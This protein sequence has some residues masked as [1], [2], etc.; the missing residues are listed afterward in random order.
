MKSWKRL[1]EYEK[2][3]IKDNYLKQ[4]IYQ[5]ADILN[6]SRE[7]IRYFVKKEGLVRSKDIKIKR[8]RSHVFPHN[9]SKST[10]FKKGCKAVSAKPIGFISE[11]KRRGK[12][13]KNI[14]VSEKKWQLYHEYVWEQHNG[15][16]PERHFVKFKDGNQLNTDISNL[17]LE[18]LEYHLT[19]NRYKD[20]P[21]ELIPTLYEIQKINNKVKQLENGTEQT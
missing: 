11:I 5:I 8:R 3:Y 12:T 15:K 14:K 20:Y 6:R 19:K 9:K 13:W 7:T 21:D 16:M 10:R 2:Q 1:T 4:S 18:S 17:Y